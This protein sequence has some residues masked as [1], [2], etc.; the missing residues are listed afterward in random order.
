MVSV[1]DFSR[2]LCGGTHC[3]RTGDIGLFRIVSESGIAAGVRRIEAVTG[4]AAYR[5]A[6]DLEVK[7]GRLAEVLKAPRE[8][9]VERA[10]EL[11]DE[12]RQ[13]AR[14]LEK[15][16]RQSFAGAAG[17][18]PFRERVRVGDTVVIAGSLPDAKPNDL[19]L[20]SDQLRKQH[21][22]IALLLGTASASSANLL[23][24]LSKDL[25][26][27]GLHAGDIIKAAAKLIGGGGGGRPD[28]AQAGGRRPDGLE[29]ALDAGVE[30]LRERLEA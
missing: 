23:C 30:Q 26:E 27:R 24:S 22:S 6:V 25:V 18:G 5:R 29:A 17:D 2:E 9:L 1:G 10:Q 14:E 3:A 15:A 7:L 13:L 12:A 28:M 11:I 8:R 21:A 20:A 19:R 16:K 4:H